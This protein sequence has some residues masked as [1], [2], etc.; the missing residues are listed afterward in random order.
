MSEARHLEE[1]P[2]PDLSNAPLEPWVLRELP[3][4]AKPQE[5]N[6][7]FRKTVRFTDIYS[8]HRKDLRHMNRVRQRQSAGLPPRRD[9]PPPPPVPSGPDWLLVQFQGFLQQLQKQLAAAPR[10]VG[11]EEAGASEEAAPRIRPVRTPRSNVPLVAAKPA[12]LLKPE[13]HKG[14]LY[15]SCP[16][17]RFPAVLPVWLAGKRARCPRCYSALRAPHPRKGLRTL[18]LEN[19]KES[20]LHP[21]SFSQYYSAHRLIPW[22]GIPRP[23]FNPAFNAIAVSILAVLLAFWIPSLLERAGRDMS[24][25]AALAQSPHRAE[26]SG[27]KERARRTV[28]QF[29][30]AESGSKASFV[31]EPERVAP[32]MADWYQRRQ[33]GAPVIPR[34]IEA[35]GAGFFS[36]ESSHPVTDVRVELPDGKTAYY[37]VEHRPDGDRIE[38]EASVGYSADFDT[39]LSRGPAAGPQPVR[40]LAAFD[41][42]YN[43]AFNDPEKHL[44]LRLH[45]PATLEF[46]GYAYLPAREDVALP[47]LAALDGSS[48]DDLRPVQL[49]VQAVENGAQSRQVEVKHFIPT[50]WR[51]APAMV[52]AGSAGE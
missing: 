16:C 20:V 11:G 27:F 3:T 31:R 18:V 52:E 38:W 26:G 50:G 33:S 34:A 42:Y 30:A 44:C 47:A 14:R 5:W 36:G 1:T 28:E 45:D 48:V 46:L 39:I 15:F 17:C 4:G 29:L 40:A 51:N 23:Q 6:H 25:L 22:L 37:T 9:S 8:E 24:R 19:D 7:Q 2:A 32:L 21:E 43:F 10:S 12:E 35:G 41:D 49:E 13:F